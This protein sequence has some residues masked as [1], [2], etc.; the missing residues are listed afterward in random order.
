MEGMWR[1]SA[2]IDSNGIARWTT[3]SRKLPPPNDVWSSLSGSDGPFCL[4]SFT[5]VGYCSLDLPV[6]DGHLW[7]ALHPLDPNMVCGIT[8]LG[9][10]LC[11][12]KAAAVLWENE[13][14]DWVELDVSTRMVCAL[15]V[16][17]RL[18]CWTHEFT[19][20]DVPSEVEKWDTVSA[21]CGLSQGVVYCWGLVQAGFPP[22]INVPWS[23]LAL[24]YGENLGCGITSEGQVYC[25]GHARVSE[26]LAPSVTHELWRHVSGWGRNFCGITQTFKVKCWGSAENELRL[27]T[28]LSS[29]RWS[30][31]SVSRS[32]CGITVEGGLHCWGLCLSGECAV[33][34]IA[35]E[36]WRYVN[37]AKS[38]S[39]GVTERGT[40]YCWGSNVTDWEP[41]QV[42]GT[43]WSRLSMFIRG[44]STYVCGLSASGE[45]YCWKDQRLYDIDNNTTYRYMAALDVD[46]VGGIGIN[47]ITEDGTL[48][49][50]QGSALKSFP[51]N[52]SNADITGA[53]F[54]VCAV[55]FDGTLMCTAWAHNHPAL[56]EPLLWKEVAVGD[57]TICGILRNGSMHCFSTTVA[58]PKAS[59]SSILDIR[60]AH[61]TSLTYDDTVL[62]GYH[63]LLQHYRCIGLAGSS[64]VAP[65][66]K[67][68]VMVVAEGVLVR[69]PTSSQGIVPSG[70][71]L[72]LSTHSSRQ[73]DM[74]VP[75]DIVNTASYH[76]VVVLVTQVSSSWM[77]VRIDSS[78]PSSDILANLR[79]LP[80][81][82]PFSS[83][84]CSRTSV[85]VTD[86]TGKTAC[87]GYLAEFPIEFTNL[88]SVDVA[89]S[90]ACGL[91]GDGPLYCWGEG[92][93][94]DAVGSMNDHFLS[95]SVSESAICG[96]LR[97]L[98]IHCE[99]ASEWVNHFAVFQ[100]EVGFTEVTVSETMICGSHFNGRLLCTSPTIEFSPMISPD[101]SDPL[102]VVGVVGNTSFQGEVEEKEACASFDHCIV[103]LPVARL[104]PHDVLYI[105]QDA[106]ITSPLESSATF[107]GAR[108]MSPWDRTKRLLV[109]NTG[110]NP[111]IKILPGGSFHLSNLEIHLAEASSG[112]S[113][114][115]RSSVVL[116]QVDIHMFGGTRVGASVDIRETIEVFVSGCA[117]YGQPGCHGQ[118]TT[119][120]ESLAVHG[121]RYLQLESNN[122][123][124]SCSSPVVVNFTSEPIKSF[125][126]SNCNFEGLGPN[127]GSYAGLQVFD[128]SILNSTS[129][130]I[131]SDSSFVR[132]GKA[133][134]GAAVSWIR[135][136]PLRSPQ[137]LPCF[138]CS[139]NAMPTI[140]FK[141]VR[142]S[143]NVATQSGGGLYAEGVK[144][145][146]RGV[147]AEGNNAYETGGAV[148][149]IGGSLS[150]NNCTLDGNRVNAQLLP[151]L[152][153]E[154]RVGGGAVSIELCDMDGLRVVSSFFRENSVESEDNVV[155]EGGAVAS[156][157]CDTE[158]VNSVF[159]T[160]GGTMRGGTISL[161]R[162]SMSLWS[163]V[164]IEDSYA[165]SQGGGAFIHDSAVVIEQTNFFL[166]RASLEPIA[167]EVQDPKLL[168]GVGGGIMLSGE[169]DVDILASLMMNSSAV[170]GGGIFVMCSARIHIEESL[171]LS[172]HANVSG[173][174]YFSLCPTPWLR[175]EQREAH[176]FI[177]DDSPMTVGSGP[178]KVMVLNK[179]SGVL[180]GSDSWSWVADFGLFDT[181]SDLVVTENQIVCT[182]RVENAAPEG[183]TAT[184]VTA[185]GFTALSGIIRVD[186]FAFEGAESIHITVALT[187]GS[188]AAVEVTVP[189]IR[190]T[191]SWET[192]PPPVWVPSFGSLLYPVRPIPEVLL[193]FN[194]ITLPPSTSVVCQASISTAS[195]A[196][197][198]VT[199]LNAPNDG[200]RNSP[201][202][203]V[204]LPTIYIS[205]AIGSLLRLVVSCSR[206]SEA[207][208]PLHFDLRL[209]SPTLRWVHPPASVAGSGKAI[210]PFLCSLESAQF[211]PLDGATCSI[212]LARA[213]MSEPGVSSFP[214]FLLGHTAVVANGLA[215]WD[216]LKIEGIIGQVY[217]L[218]TTCAVGEYKL[219][220]SLVVDIA[221]STC[222]VGFEPTADQRGCSQCAK[223]MYSDGA[224]Q[225]CHLCP[226]A[227]AICSG[228][229]LSLLDDY[230]PSDSRFL[231][232]SVSSK[233]TTTND[234]TDLPPYNEATTLYPCP[235]KGVCFVH[236]AT[237]RYYCSEGYSG[238]LC[239]VCDESQSFVSY[240]AH[241]TK[242]W[243]AWISVLFLVAI[244]LLCLALLVYVT[245][246]RRGGSS[247]PMKI[248]F[249]LTVSYIQM[250]SSLSQFKVKATDTVQEV[251]S[252]ADSI[253]TGIADFP[254]L[255]CIVRAPYYVRFA[256]SM[257]LPAIA[258]VVVVAITCIAILYQA[259]ARHWRRL[260]V[261]Q[262]L[263]TSG[264]TTEPKAHRSHDMVRPPTSSLR[265]TVCAYLGDKPYLGPMLFVYF[266]FYN[267]LSSTAMGMFRCGQEVFDGAQFL[268][269]DRTVVCFTAGHYAGMMAA[270]LLA[271][272][273]NVVVPFLLLCV[274]RRNKR[275]L[276]TS[277]FRS[278][279]GFLYQGYS[280]E[281]GLYW[282]EIVVLLRK[283]LVLA[284]AS[285][286][287]D[288]FL[289]SLMGLALLGFFLTLQTHYRP[290]QRDVWNR[291]ETMV[292]GCLC[293]TQLL[294]LSY[295]RSVEE[296][297]SPVSST[298]ITWLLLSLNAIVLLT[299]VCV[300]ILQFFAHRKTRQSRE[301]R[302]VLAGRCDAQV[303]GSTDGDPG[304]RDSEGIHQVNPTFRSQ[305]RGK[306]KHDRTIENWARPIVTSPWHW[307]GM[308]ISGSN[309]IVA[310]R[311][312]QMRRPPQATVGKHS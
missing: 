185:S 156:Y 146:M 111:C 148:R 119:S 149:A 54:Q 90:F 283:F 133:G 259:C 285:V 86:T 299:L 241:C 173:T 25:W 23:R 87:S 106:N 253:G 203:K 302:V 269:L 195:Y 194:E 162:S 131:I 38:A 61:L 290:Y 268:E 97:N 213:N 226:P 95:I 13:D 51:G 207:L 117:W 63:V 14:R 292:L 49:F 129:S 72:T 274:L 192:P 47:F 286:I 169:S 80:L 208:Q 101:Y 56:G 24:N 46:S 30:S 254:P 243:P 125:Q 221:L 153:L 265:R 267:S 165:A 277:K 137:E 236:N 158:I 220:G 9:K 200:Y 312:L 128:R 31:V 27:P 78:K 39:C 33:P 186:N 275:R 247:S 197:P 17:R 278:R 74:V 250:L 139:A 223:K 273:L 280:I 7:R 1:R 85:C 271:V 222:N 5:G 255:R 175:P 52:W 82:G 306:I 40:G 193:S 73:V 176:R 270:G 68:E 284:L 164:D 279:F 263:R 15:C 140:V 296:Q 209:S 48:I 276:Q 37:T 179:T 217:Q 127:T 20:V 22:Q 227:G 170:F 19:S 225:P 81:A 245:L 309:S 66:R 161:R 310:Q 45:G 246:F 152:S 10:A 190:L 118:A 69:S 83:V 92:V 264:K 183:A 124:S 272:V 262:S 244:V 76:E 211:P 157:D 42:R 58:V 50:F 189:V 230:F 89:D 187:C 202:H 8:L 231:A 205:G 134:N 210:A 71:I 126:V 293:T 28:K 103:Q 43:Q 240:G 143:G 180:E 288:A 287:S 232:S 100:G 18:S 123:F 113:I 257:S 289:Q 142:F 167:G 307:P 108:A 260:K 138:Q 199:I 172:N 301:K 12:D 295:F 188:L 163:R 120:T 3:T 109:C 91:R 198:L 67:N 34:S 75:F 53:D 145:V 238:P 147:R 215:R 79:A 11:W 182:L 235:V 248:V 62:C 258:G 2:G 150:L 219:P 29:L 70:T 201:I 218:E 60:Y 154:S 159:H 32:A 214:P 41:A 99:G 178:V 229:F 311:T 282:W 122:W 16:E 308:P 155:S 105:L 228:G 266:F 300:G 234:L 26:P 96:V 132:N 114:T 171:C 55:D 237:R 261:N 59:P 112:F 181:N 107:V 115:G 304:S 252:F 94:V 216:E 4:V 116:H 36:K 84:S 224:L 256:T 297:S 196:T 174:S 130:I 151:S 168:G 44:N 291:L 251:F 110:H 298:V 294:S 305:P 98:T 6:L 93:L 303:E 204:S 144:V 64:V 212:T 249:R 21:P 242:C 233:S 239:A 88:S 160:N 184:L 177:I 166:C 65:P 104:P 135:K 281:R 136:D 57:E 35:G 77:Y 102:L 206:G 141:N 191:T 121:A